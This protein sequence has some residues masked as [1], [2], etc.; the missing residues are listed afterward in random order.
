[1][2]QPD[3]RPQASDTQ[4]AAWLNEAAAHGGRPADVSGLDDLDDVTT[5]AAEVLEAHGTAHRIENIALYVL[6]DGSGEALLSVEPD[7]GPRLCS[8]TFRAPWDSPCSPGEAAQWLLGAADEETSRLETF[9]ATGGRHQDAAL[10]G[11]ETRRAADAASRAAQDALDDLVHDT[12]SARASAACND[13][14]AGQAAYL[15]AE[16]GPAAAMAALSS[17]PAR[18]DLP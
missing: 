17:L 9:R 2:S 18:K 15:L 14:P 4:L 11:D 16:L 10:L 13:G 3:P 5:L 8:L 6:H 1:M 12:A 7:H